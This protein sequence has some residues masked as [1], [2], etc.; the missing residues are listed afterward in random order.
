MHPMKNPYP[1]HPSS[2]RR[3][4]PEL[5]PNRVSLRL[6]VAGHEASAASGALK[7]EEYEKTPGAVFGQWRVVAAPRNA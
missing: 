5:P 3:G 2:L 6:V 1:F 4:A 7:R